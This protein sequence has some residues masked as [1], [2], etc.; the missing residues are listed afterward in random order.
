MAGDKGAKEIIKH[1][2][3]LLYSLDKPEKAAQAVKESQKLYETVK[4]ENTKRKKFYTLM[5]LGALVTFVVAIV[6]LAL[7]LASLSTG[8]GGMV[9]LGVSI[10]S[11]VLWVL[12]RYL[13]CSGH[14]QTQNE[15][16]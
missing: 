13:L 10:V 16:K 11:N 6:S 4:S 7:I 8:W 1:A 3:E 14:D 2:E 9:L 5:L 15:Q 12:C